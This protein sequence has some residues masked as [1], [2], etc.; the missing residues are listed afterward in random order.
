ML[1]I[2]TISIIAYI[3]LNIPIY[4]NESGHKIALFNLEHLLHPKQWWEHR[5]RLG[6]ILQMEWFD[7]YMDLL[8]KENQDLQS[9]IWNSH[10]ITLYSCFNGSGWN[11]E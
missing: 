8:F 4:T 6:N 2:S 1:P 7:L 5:E 10:Q 3:E 11:W 9:E